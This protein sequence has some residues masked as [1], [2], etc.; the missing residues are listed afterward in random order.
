MGARASS[1]RHNTRG[2]R[3]AFRWAVLYATAPDG[4][5]R[6]PS[7]RPARRP[8]AG[9]PARPELRR[10]RSAAVDRSRGGA[11]AG[12]LA[13]FDALGP[14]TLRSKPTAARRS[15]TTCSASCPG[16]WRP[17][18]ATGSPIFGERARLGACARDRSWEPLSPATRC[19]RS[20]PTAREARRGRSSGPPC[21]LPR[22]RQSAA[23]TD[24]PLPAQ[25]ESERVASEPST[26][27]PGD[28]VPPASGSPETSDNG[29]RPRSRLGGAIL[30][31][32][33]ALVVVRSGS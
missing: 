30:L 21:R 6:Q 11:R 16:R 14:Q 15:P 5:P 12:E 28:R 23:G 18:R 2:G 20:R 3:P 33:G 4:F 26:P 24:A 13:A 9:P 32:L 27:D 31:G 1:A 8:A 29:A 10:H 25:V 22:L 19:R 7:A 17:T